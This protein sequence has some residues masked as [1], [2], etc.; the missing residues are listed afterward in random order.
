MICVIPFHAGDVHLAQEL[1]RW[2]EDLGGCGNHE[3]LLLADRATQWNQCIS[4]MESAQKSFRKVHF[5]AT[6]SE[7]NF[8]W[9]QAANAMFKFASK[10][11]EE[12][13]DSHWLWLE[14]DAAPLKPGWLDQLDSAY[15]ASGRRFMG[16][17][18]RS[19]NPNIPE[20]VLSGVAVYPQ[21]C[22]KDAEEATKGIAAFDVILSKQQNGAVAHSNL[23]HW[24]WGEKREV[25]PRFAE[26]NAPGTEIFCLRQLHPEA[27]I[28]HRCKDGSLIRLLR[29][30]LFPKSDNF[31]VAYPFFSIDAPL[32]LKN[33]RWMQELRQPRTHEMRLFYESTTNSKIV[34]EI[35]MACA[36]IFTAVK[37][38]PYRPVV[39]PNEVW[40]LVALEM[41]RVKRNWLWMEPDAVPLKQDWLMKLQTGYSN[42]K[43]QFFGPI[44][45]D[46]LH[47]NGTAI[48]PWNTPELCPAT[49][50]SREVYGFDVLMSGEITARIH[51]ASNLFHHVWVEKHGR[52]L[53]HGDGEYPHFPTVDSL[54]RLQKGA[55]L[56]HR[57]KDGSLID[58]LR[59]KGKV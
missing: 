27:V 21:N 17:V 25:A 13:L 16:C 26:V 53:P 3:A 10:Y 37:H 19:N 59:E 33:I 52:L 7:Y 56:F 8:G 35:A 23:I 1:M 6:D 2:I 43:K 47:M 11:V 41:Q 44:V 30:Q 55:V 20:P 38:T 45:P 42:A 5:A 29:E 14:P 57:C 46:M 51:D 49:F 4:L 22:L 28:F 31:V 40:K 58:R 34:N 36:P 9:P 24:V 18:Y 50:S 54:N 32:A 48:Y 12:N 39:G 15:K